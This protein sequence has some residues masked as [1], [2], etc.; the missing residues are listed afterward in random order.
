MDLRRG[1]VATAAPPGSFSK[2]R[3]VLVIEDEA[4]SFT[5]T[6][7]VALIT[8]DLLRRPAVRVPITPSASNGLRIPSEVMVDIIQTLPK[9]RQ[10]RVIGNVDAVTLRQ[11]DAALR[12]HLGL[13]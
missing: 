10:G 7:T 9:Q 1:V 5:E 6:V 11:V 12:L 13:P 4:G 8:S 2:P 3:P